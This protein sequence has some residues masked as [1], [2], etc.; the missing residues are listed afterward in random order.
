[1]FVMSTR[2]S[3]A[4]LLAEGYSAKAIADRLLLAGTTVSYHIERLR[5]PPQPKPRRRRVRVETARI[6]GSTR[7]QVSVLLA[8]G[9][10][11]SEI[12]RRL[13]VSKATISY[14]ARRLGAPVDERGARR[15]DWEAIQRYYDEGHSVRDCVAAFGFSHETWQSAKK[16]GAITTRPQTTPAAELFVAGQP[17]SRSNLRRRL[18]TEG[19]K[20]SVCAIC[21]VS[22]W[23]DQ[24]LSLALHHINGD[25]IDN[26]LE[27]LE[28]LCPN[29]HSQTD[30]YSGRNGHR[31]R[32]RAEPAAAA[33]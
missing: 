7:K 19:L 3:I 4:Q 15:Y 22:E 14:H 1:M 17:R 18:L 24:P 6:H 8:E 5:N 9:L 16:R 30:S 27:N 10:N 20:P 11:R 33:P 12:A 25:R 2:E 23:L 13:G 31:R 28:L 21:G 32:G 26:R 29:C